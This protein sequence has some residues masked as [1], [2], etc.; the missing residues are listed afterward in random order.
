[1][2]HIDPSTPESAD[3]QFNLEP[4][5]QDVEVNRRRIKESLRQV[6]EIEEEV[7]KPKYQ[8]SILSIMLATAFVA[9]T[10]GVSQLLPSAILAGVLGVI[11]CLSLVAMLKMGK[12]RPGLQMAWGVFGLVYVAIAIFA[13]I[14]ALQN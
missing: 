13:T 7:E 11:A 5:D 9:I 12:E 4:L 8:F 14:K 6:G 3:D 1:M 2:P 10:F